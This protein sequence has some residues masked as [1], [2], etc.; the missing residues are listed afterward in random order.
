MFKPTDA[1]LVVIIGKLHNLEITFD[2]TM[3]K[4]RKARYIDVL[5]NL[6]IATYVKL[7]KALDMAEW[8]CTHFPVPAD[9]VEILQNTRG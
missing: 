9:I 5:V 6:Q 2:M 3:S 7:C 4:E 8:Q 1:E